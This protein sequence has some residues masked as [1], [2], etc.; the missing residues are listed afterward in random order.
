MRRPLLFGGYPIKE[1]ANSDFI[2]FNKKSALRT[3]QRIFDEW[4]HRTQLVK[5]HTNAESAAN[6]AKTAR[7]RALRLEKEARDA[8]AARL[9][10]PSPPL[11]QP[12]KRKKTSS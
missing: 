5:L 1:N 2:N 12:K 4:E 3:A 7:L 8:E 10:P 9:N 6:D 11:S